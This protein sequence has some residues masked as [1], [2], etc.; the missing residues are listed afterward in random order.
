M[1]YAVI[2]LSL[3]VGINFIDRV[4]VTNKYKKVLKENNAIRMERMQLMEIEE[5]RRADLAAK[6]ADLKEWFASYDAGELVEVYVDMEGNKWFTFADIK[7]IPAKRGILAELATKYIDMNITSARLREFVDKISEN[8]NEGRF[9]KAAALLELLSERLNWSCEEET[10]MQFAKVYFLME[11]EP[12]T[13]GGPGSIQYEKQK[14][15]IL[16]KDLAARAFFLTRAFILT[17][18]YSDISPEN[19]L[20]YLEQKKGALVNEQLILASS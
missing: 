7:Q 1:L 14:D 15:A 16:R 19:I 9:I 17:K 10:L 4:L 6:G 11:G 20:E 3:I 5:K 13:G 8:V 12:I 18:N 2:I